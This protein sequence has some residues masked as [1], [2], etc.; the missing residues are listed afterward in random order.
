MAILPERV[1]PVTLLGQ[2]KQHGDSKQRSQ[3]RYADN[4]RT[5]PDRLQQ[6]PV[7]IKTI[8]QSNSGDVSEDRSDL[9]TITAETL[10]TVVNER[11]EAKVGAPDCG[12]DANTDSESSEEKPGIVV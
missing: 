5:P 10:R 2:K 1:Q 6:Q 8:K 12:N 7:A 3:N 4:E 11:E 9:V